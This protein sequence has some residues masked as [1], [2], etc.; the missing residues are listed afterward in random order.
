MK[1]IIGVKQC[2]Y[3]LLNPALW[4]IVDGWLIASCRWCQESID[5]GIQ[6]FLKEKFGK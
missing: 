4:R 6:E 3:C 5:K 1:M 2:P